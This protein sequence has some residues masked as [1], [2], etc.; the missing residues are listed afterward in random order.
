[1]PDGVP[2]FSPI[3]FESGILCQIRDI[4]VH[5]T[6]DFNMFDDL[7]AIGLQPA[8]KI[9]QILDARDFACSGTNSL[10]G[11]VFDIGSYLFCFQPETNRS[12]LP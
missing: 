10:V 11:N 9:V 12:R 4:T 8:V 5:L 1:M 3:F 6:I 2:P 7:F